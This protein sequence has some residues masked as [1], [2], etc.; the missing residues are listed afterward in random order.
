MVSGC[1]QVWPR[2]HVAKHGAYDTE[3]ANFW[4]ITNLNTIGKML[5]HLTQNQICR[6][7]QGSPNFSAP[8]SAYRAHHSMEAAMTRVVNDL[9]AAIDK[10]TP[11]VLLSLDISAAFDTLDH[12]RLIEDAKNLSGL[13]D[14]VL[15]W[16][17]LYLTDHTQCVCWWLLLRHSGDDIRH[18]LRFEGLV[19]W[20]HLCSLFTALVG[21]LINSSG[22]NYHQ[23]TDDTQLY[24]VI[25]LST[26]IPHCLA[27]LTACA[28]AVT[29]WHIL[30][31]LLLNP[32]KTKTLVT[33]IR[34]R[35]LS[36]TH[37]PGWWCPMTSC[38][39]LQSYEYSV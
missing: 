11:S 30:N 20:L 27:S 31:D 12:H 10:K 32:N 33:N 8:Q 37:P 4:P 23:F 6:H 3:M 21:T 9:L 7:I 1:V 28:D 22:I 39:S 19:L 26:L 38:R 5:E 18:S 2:I 16:L 15:E 24:I 36:W 17:W 34:H 35:W 25:K 14:L 13:D 29:G